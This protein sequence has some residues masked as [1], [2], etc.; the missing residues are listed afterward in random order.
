MT[1]GEI[2]YSEE[3]PIKVIALAAIE[4][5]SPQVKRLVFS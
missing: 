3:Y 5:E 4:M 2:T 1:N